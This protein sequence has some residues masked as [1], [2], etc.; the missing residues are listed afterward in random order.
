MIWKYEIIN[1]HG[2]LESGNWETEMK[3]SEICRYFENTNAELLSLTRVENA[4]I[5]NAH[6]DPHTKEYYFES[7]EVKGLRERVSRLI[8]RE[9]SSAMEVAYASA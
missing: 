7:P 1:R 9:G 3:P 8:R 6:Y 4:V 2:D 5:V